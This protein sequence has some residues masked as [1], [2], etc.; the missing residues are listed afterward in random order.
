MVVTVRRRFTGS[1]GVGGGRPNRAVGG[2]ITISHAAVAAVGVG[3]R[4]RRVN[5]VSGG[6][7]GGMMKGPRRRAAR[8]YGRESTV[9]APSVRLRQL[10]SYFAAAC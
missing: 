4:P 5:T 9:I 3:S 7:R 1:G 2:R 6:H 8:P 10:A